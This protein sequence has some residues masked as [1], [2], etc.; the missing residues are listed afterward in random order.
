M[1]LKDE[2]SG[3]ERRSDAEQKNADVNP[4]EPADPPDHQGDEAG[5]IY[6]DPEKTTKEFET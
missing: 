2:L 4:E 1:N 3:S 5:D 6:T